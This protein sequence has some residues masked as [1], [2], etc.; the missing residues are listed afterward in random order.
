MRVLRTVIW[1]PAADSPLPLLI[2]AHGFGGLPEK[3][4]AFA[5]TVADAGFVVAAPAF[6]LTNQNAPG[7]HEQ[8]LSDFRNQPGDVSFVLDRLLEASV[9]PADDL[10]ESIDAENIALLGHSLGGLTALGTTGKNCCRDHRITALITVAPLISLFLNQFGADPLAIDSPVLLIHGQD[11]P[12]V[13]FQSS[14]DLSGNLTSPKFLIGLTGAGHSDLLE[15]QDE[16]APPPRRA[17]E[18]AT[19]AFLNAVFH[20]DMPGFDRLLDE[21]ATSGHFVEKTPS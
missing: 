20:D 11:D 13:P 9:D 3:F 7:G 16:P 10:Y 5:R 1:Q 15:S 14:I 19:T 18:D 4:D 21:L 8:G 2:L 17:A 6:P 12:T